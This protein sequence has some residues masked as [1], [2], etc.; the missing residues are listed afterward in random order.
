MRISFR[1]DDYLD[2]KQEGLSEAARILEDA[3]ARGETIH[4]ALFE[5]LEAANKADLARAWEFDESRQ[6][7]VTR[8]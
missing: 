1:N 8:G 3:I 7:F 4:A 6:E 5:M 2:G